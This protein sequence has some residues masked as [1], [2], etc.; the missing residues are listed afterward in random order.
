MRGKAVLILTPNVF[1]ESC[2]RGTPE[3]VGVEATDSL[4][5]AA[6]E[7]PPLPGGHK[8]PSL[9]S[10][11]LKFRV[12]RREGSYPVNMGAASGVKREGPHF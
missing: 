5:A 9:A 12:A 7:P 1:G 8:G 6:G 10:T 4:T 11:S 2:R 3:G